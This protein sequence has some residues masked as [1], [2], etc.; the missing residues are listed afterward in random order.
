MKYW[1]S[2]SEKMTEEI[3]ECYGLPFVD[4]QEEWKGGGKERGLVSCIHQ[5]LWVPGMA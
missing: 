1:T 4:E 2:N 3:L 5:K